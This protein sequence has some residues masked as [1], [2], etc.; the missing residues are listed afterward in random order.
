[1][2]LLPAAIVLVTTLLPTTIMAARV[3]PHSAIRKLTENKKSEKFA[4]SFDSDFHHRIIGGEVASP[5]DYPFFVDWGGCGATLVHEDIIVTAAHCAEVLADTTDVYVGAFRESQETDG[6]EK[7]L[8]VD[9][10]VHPD[11]DDNT[12]E[13]DV[14][15]LKIDTASSHPPVI[16]NDKFS[17]P[18][19]GDDLITIGHGVTDVNDPF[20]TPSE[21][22]QVTVP[23][24]PHEDCAEDYTTIQD[25]DPFFDLDVV[26][27]NMICAGFEQGGKDSCQ[28]DSGGPLLKKEGSNFVQVGITSW[29][30]D[31]AA[32][33]SPGVYT[34]VSAVKGWI[35]EQICIFSDN[36]PEGCEGRNN[37]DEDDEDQDGKFPVL[38]E[39]TYDEYPGETGWSVSQDGNVIE[40]RLPGTMTQSGLTSER[41]FL[42]PG[43]YTFTITD[44]IGDGTCCLY[45]EGSWQIIAELDGYDEVLVAGDGEFGEEASATFV[46]ADQGTTKASCDDSESERFLVDEIIG[47]Q[48]CAWLDENKDRFRYLCVFI[49]VAL[50]CPKTCDICDRI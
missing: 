36:P 27:E 31:C 17:E 8:V 18:S 21:L 3:G 50:A 24:V 34:R 30:N 48:G 15:I 9:S 41:I 46:V 45:G 16:L 5:G 25:E 11:Y 32:A 14:M 40:S 38:I 20:T 22:Y 19:E 29:G 47:D 35:D 39:V 12:I 44:T 49:D 1:M 7:R 37:P 26:E 43:E 10:I 4:K 13:N 33:N 6:A 42:A 2:K 23:F 28:G